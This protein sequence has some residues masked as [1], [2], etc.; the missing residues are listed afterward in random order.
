[1]QIL[2]N[3]AVRHLGSHLWQKNNVASPP[4][5]K[6]IMYSQLCDR[7]DRAKIGLHAI[8]VDSRA[9]VAGRRLTACVEL[10]G[11]Q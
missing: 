8:D 9:L 3:D 5:K 4:H 7:W 10:R 11:A 1:M 6:A 2:I